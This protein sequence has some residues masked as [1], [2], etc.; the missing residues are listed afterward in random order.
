MFHK[1]K[2]TR[3]SKKNYQLLLLKTKILF[4]LFY[5]FWDNKTGESVEIST[6]S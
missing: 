6:K 5:T 3:H 2:K 1:N 4:Q